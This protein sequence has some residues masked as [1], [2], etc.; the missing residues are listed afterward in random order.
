MTD[1]VQD[2]FQLKKNTPELKA[3]DRVRVH[4]KIKEGGKERTQ[5]F[6]GL[7]IKTKGGR[8]IG[9]S[10]TVRRISLGVGV[11]K[12]YPLH[13]PTIT[14]IEKVKSAKVRR[15]KL[16]FVRDLTGKKARRLKSEKD[17]TGVWENVIADEPTISGEDEKPEIKTQNDKAKIIN[18]KVKEP[19][20][21]TDKVKK[22][23]AKTEEKNVNQRKSKSPNRTEKRANRRRF[24]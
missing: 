1:I 17:E 4:Q 24:S 15:A 13:L 10:F 9:G 18:D 16:Y 3:G 21:T 12:T 5:I 23:E 22:R 8:G 2:H 7:V 20:G 19:E 14:K 11:E 6:E